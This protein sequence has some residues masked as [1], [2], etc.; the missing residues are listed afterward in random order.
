MTVEVL[1]ARGEPT[2]EVLFGATHNDLGEFSIV[3]VPEGPVRVTVH[4]SYYDEVDDAISSEPMT[5]R[6][7]GQARAGTRSNVN[8]L[9]HIGAERGRG[10]YAEGECLG[11]ALRIARDEVV[12]MLLVGTSEYAMLHAA[13]EVS[14]VGE[15]IDDN[16]YLLVV[17]LI[18][19]EGAHQGPGAQDVVDRLADRLIDD[20]TWPYTWTPQSLE[21]SLPADQLVQRVNLYLQS[22]GVAAAA[23]NVHRILDL[24][25]DGI[26]DLDDNCPYV[27]NFD[28]NDGDDD[29]IGDICDCGE[30]AC[31]CGLD[32]PDV[33]DDGYPDACDNCPDVANAY[34]PQGYV[35]GSFPSDTD[36]DGLGNACD[37]C[38]KTFETGS[39]PG[40]QCCSP[41]QPGYGCA[42]DFFGSIAWNICTYRS[43]RFVCEKEWECTALF[44]YG[45]TPCPQRPKAPPGALAKVCDADYCL[46]CEVEA[47]GSQW[48]DVLEDTCSGD[49]NVCLRWFE[50]GEAPE[51]LENLGVC[52]RVDQGPC[53]DLVGRQCIKIA[54]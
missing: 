43:G 15:D 4:G 38:P 7:F 54:S 26:A 42:K 52:A 19:A 51:F 40:E 33:D 3:E 41:L 10:L 16:A 49:L 47:C 31:A 18:V 25:D 22:L 45:R 2:G 34:P 39:V 32:D 8:V 11:D 17:S 29:G 53:V 9:T 5:L 23:P 27:P 6:A 30:E 28:Q 50:P 46:D 12:D 37:S 35:G 48:C 24:D 14:V 13:S 21:L 20:E 44:G 1:D 36:W